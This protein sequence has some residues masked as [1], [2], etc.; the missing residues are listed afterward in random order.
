MNPAD[1]DYICGFVRDQAAIVLEPGKEY[2]VE[3]R[4]QTLARK[5]NLGS[6]DA[7]ISNLRADPKNGLHRKVLDAMTTNETS[8]FRDLYPFEALRKSILPELTARRAQER[9]LRF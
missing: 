7:L 1:F 6:L 8:F 4:L 9:Q 3:S 5:E 2:L